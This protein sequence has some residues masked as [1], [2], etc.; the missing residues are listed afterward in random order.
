MDPSAIF[1]ILLSLA[2]THLK[3]SSF[4][5]GSDY[6]GDIFGFQTSYGHSGPILS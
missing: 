3:H 5:T 2:F 1:P 6:I 4:F